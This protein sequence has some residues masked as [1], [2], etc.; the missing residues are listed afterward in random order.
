MFPI[1]VQNHRVDAGGVVVLLIL[2]ALEPVA[3]AV[4]E[5]LDHAHV[6]QPV[7]IRLG[8]GTALGFIRWRADLGRITRALGGG[9]AIA[10]LGGRASTGALEHAARETALL[11]GEV[12]SKT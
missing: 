9:R 7:I 8:V 11:V 2:S 5:E 3:D 12:G 6:L 10:L 1:R 4:A